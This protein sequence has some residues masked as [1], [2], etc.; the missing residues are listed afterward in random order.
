MPKTTPPLAVP[1]SLVRITP[2]SGVASVKTSA[3]L[4]PFWPVV[5]SSTSKTS[6]G[7]SGASRSMIRRILRS[8]SIKL[9][10]L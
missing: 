9:A 8:S 7:T 4:T 1:S 6:I 3:C 5:A 10:L 2:V